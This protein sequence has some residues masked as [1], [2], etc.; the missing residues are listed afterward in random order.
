MIIVRAE[1]TIGE[2][3]WGMGETVA[4]AVENVRECCEDMEFFETTFFDA[5]EIKVEKRVKYKILD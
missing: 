3:F 5:K 4:D 2:E 1:S